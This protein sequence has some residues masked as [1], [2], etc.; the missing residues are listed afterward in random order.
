M[1]EQAAD[2]V[3][4]LQAARNYTLSS[5]DI[6]RIVREKREK[7]LVKRSLAHHKA[8]LIL[9]LNAA[10]E[11]GDTDA[12]ARCAA[13][14][15]ATLPAAIVWQSTARQAALSCRGCAVR[16]QFGL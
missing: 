8:E 5:E 9:A 12:E 13:C 11:V 14:P 2:A 7:G 10:R 4:K 15:Q 6:G 1:S 3:V 16:G